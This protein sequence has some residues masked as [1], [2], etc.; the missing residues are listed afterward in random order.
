M[1]TTNHATLILASLQRAPRT[2]QSYDLSKTAR[3]RVDAVQQ[4]L[5]EYQHRLAEFDHAGALARIDRAYG[6]LGADPPRATP[7]DMDRSAHPMMMAVAYFTT[8]AP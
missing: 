8:L 5:G 7:A 3:Q 2:F 6:V 4:L 1:F